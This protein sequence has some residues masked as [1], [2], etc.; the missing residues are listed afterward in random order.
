MLL[1]ASLPAG[2]QAAGIVVESPWWTNKPMLTGVGRAAIRAVHEGHV[3]AGADVVRAAT[4]HCSE[5]EL[6]DLGLAPGSGTAWMVHAAVGVA[7]TAGART[8]VGS[9]G[10]SPH[11]H[12]W[13]VTELTRCGVDAILA[14][15]MPSIAEAVGVVEQAQVRTWV[16]FQ[17]RQGKLLSGES[18]VDAVQQ[19]R[20]GG[21]ELVAVN[22]GTPDDLEPVL[23]QIRESYDGPLG[24]Y[25]DAT[26]ELM[27]TLRRW[28]ATYGL[29]LVGGCCG[30]TAAHLK[31]P[32]TSS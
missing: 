29:Q 22:C 2:L 8:V 19:A 21:A 20:R 10:P 12:D 23:A 26:D 13:L 6:L 31:V 9:I 25:P 24:A 27:P 18:V 28:E 11:P 17:V 5:A 3:A 14:E 32:A 30:T 15:S 1:D 16:S 7:R 4:F